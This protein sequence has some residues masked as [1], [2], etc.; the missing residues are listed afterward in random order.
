MI[1]LF[2]LIVVAVAAILGLSWQN[3]IN[4]N[5]DYQCQNCGAV[6][7]LSTFQAFVLPHMM[8]RKLVRC[9]VCGQ[10]TWAERVPKGGS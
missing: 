9:P 10:M 1:K 2:P 3:L 5:Y 4:R 6:F 8:G 7:S